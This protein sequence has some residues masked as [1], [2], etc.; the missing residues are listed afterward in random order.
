MVARALPH[1]QACTIPSPPKAAHTHSAPLPWE[2]EE[3]LPS[4]S[5]RVI[6]SG[7]C[8]TQGNPS[9][10]KAMLPVHIA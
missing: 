9:E 4:R 10:L 2:E 3:S 8:P 7:N 5:R 1:S 6:E